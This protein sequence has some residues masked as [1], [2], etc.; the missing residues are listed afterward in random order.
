M[1]KNLD[2]GQVLTS[3]LISHDGQGLLSGPRCPDEVPDSLVEIEDEGFGD[4]E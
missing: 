1:A 4:E 3:V 2:N